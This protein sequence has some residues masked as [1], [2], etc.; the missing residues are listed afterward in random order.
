MG[1]GTGVPFLSL[2]FLMQL[3]LTFFRRFADIE[4]D[5]RLYMC[6]NLKVWLTNFSSQ[7][8]ASAGTSDD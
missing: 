8:E 7:M 6:Q 1:M 5:V 2:S 4:A 3:L